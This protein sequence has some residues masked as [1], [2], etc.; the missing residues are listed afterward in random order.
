[1]QNEPT[2][3]E[4]AILRTA[5]WFSMFS[6][7]LTVFEIWKWLHK[8]SHVYDLAQVSASLDGSEWLKDKIQTFQ[9][10]YAPI[11]CD[12]NQMINLRRERFLD[13]ERKFKSLRRAARYFKLFSGVRA[14]AAVNTLAWWATEKHSD[15][16]LFVVTKPG[17]I[18]SSRF[19]LV[20]PF[21]LSGRRPGRIES[22]RTKSDP[23]CFSFFVSQDSLE[24]ESLCLSR[25]HYMAY[26]L[27]SIVPIFDR[28]ENFV[29]LWQ[30]NRWTCAFIPNAKMRQ[31][32]H[33]H[34]PSRIIGLPIQT[35]FVEP[36]FRAIERFKLPSGLRELANLDSRVVITDKM[37]KFHGNDRRAEFRDKF[38]SMVKEYL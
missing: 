34:S 26:W 2:D 30:T 25:D 14:V 4:K 35:R 33:Y 28:D 21:M 10:F 8:P 13:S 11:K 9:G 7:V 15:I 24:F 32:H 29:K 20:L 12:I 1:M 3:L 38:E 37:L 6:Q 22:E 16:D 17:N 18:W 19:F 5:V 31:A 36:L 23:F 27:K